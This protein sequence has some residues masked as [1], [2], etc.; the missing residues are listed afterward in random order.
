MANAGVLA[1]VLAAL[2]SMIAVRLHCACSMSLPSLAGGQENGSRRIKPGAVEGAG[3]TI[4][5]VNSPAAL[6]G[7]EKN[8]LGPEKNKRAE[9]WRARRWLAAD[10]KPHRQFL[11][12]Q[13]VEHRREAF[14]V[15]DGDV[16]VEQDAQP[17]GAR[18]RVCEGVAQE[19]QRAPF[20]YV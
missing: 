3:D 5:A 12:G 15:P 13:R 19:I 8:G 1:A 9:S 18:R 16:Q 11:R 20:S 2:A 10:G 4:P 14:R 7:S 17:H 6:R